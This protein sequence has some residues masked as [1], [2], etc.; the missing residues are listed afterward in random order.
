LKPAR[1]QNT[2]SQT[3]QFFCLC[4]LFMCVSVCVCVYVCVCVCVCVCICVHVCVCVCICVCVCACVCVRAY[5]C[6]YKLIA[7]IYGSLG[8]VHKLCVWSLKMAGLKK[9]DS[10]QLARYC[11]VSSHWQLLCRFYP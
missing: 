4:V 7:L 2:I 3:V 8:H 5:V 11:T 10:K 1:E 9:R 6:V